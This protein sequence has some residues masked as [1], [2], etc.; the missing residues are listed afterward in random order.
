M[1]FILETPS[2][3][4]CAVGYILSVDEAL[5]ILGLHRTATVSE[6]KEAYRDLVKVW[7]PDRF[8][9]D[10]PLRRKAEERLKQINIAYQCLQGYAS[11]PDPTP[12]K[13]QRSSETP[14]P[15]SAHRESPHA[16]KHDAGLADESSR[17]KNQLKVKVLLGLMFL[18]FILVVFF[19]ASIRDKKEPN[20]GDTASDA[21]DAS[22]P[23]AADAAP[24]VPIASTMP[25]ASG[26]SYH[27]VDLLLTRPFPDQ[28]SWVA[29]DVAAQPT[30]AYGRVVHYDTWP[31]KIP[32]EANARG[33]R[34]SQMLGQTICIFDV[35]EMV[36]G[37]DVSTPRSAGRIAVEIEAGWRVPD[38]SLIW[39][40]VPE[41]VEEVTT[42]NGTVLQLP[43]V[44]FW[45]YH[46]GQ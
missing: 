18:V 42:D 21:S 16:G 25:P 3:L 28:G 13:T 7:H 2:K 10:I 34:F 36:S 39:D 11:A 41:G 4:C 35:I 40:V 8:G 15:Y 14:P 27:A 33:V 17:R 12:H 6:I 29:L 23:T 30:V 1:W 20:H 26:H 44:K 32:D 24:P 22:T 37:E 46:W 31:G 9:N 43:K 5:D 45:R 38:S 19:I